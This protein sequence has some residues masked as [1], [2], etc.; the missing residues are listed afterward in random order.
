[1]VLLDRWDGPHD[2]DAERADASLER[3]GLAEAVGELVP[4][5]SA[6]PALPDGVARLAELAEAIG[7]VRRVG[8]REA[9]SLLP[10]V[11]QLFAEAARR[12]AI[13]GA[14]FEQWQPVAGRNAVQS[15][16]QVIVLETGVVHVLDGIGVT[17][18][19]NGDLTGAELVDSVVARHGQ[20]PG[21]DAAARVASALSDLQAVGLCL[22]RR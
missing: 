4:Q 17:I 6:L 18:W 20:A 13:R 1:V 11:E 10:V 5:S 16:S 9:A 8:Y 22:G 21:G 15:E 7:G 12:D 3:L 14:P 19:Q 2:H